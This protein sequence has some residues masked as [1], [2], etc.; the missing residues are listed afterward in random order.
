MTVKYDFKYEISNVMG[1]EG[2]ATG[3]STVVFKDFKW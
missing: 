1:S 2:T 3:A